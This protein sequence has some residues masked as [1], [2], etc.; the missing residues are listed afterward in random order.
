[1][2]AAVST[3]RDARVDP[4][5]ESR[6]AQLLEINAMNPIQTD[7]VIE[8]IRGDIH[9]SRHDGFLL[10]IMDHKS[11]LRRAYSMAAPG[12]TQ[13]T[14]NICYRLLAAVN[15]AKTQLGTVERGFRVHEA[16]VHAGEMM[17]HDSVRDQREIETQ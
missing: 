12:A 11:A 2:K 5:Y 8:V 16:A 7:S 17:A 14:L 10:E 6:V 15:A 4:P 3:R 9:V 13:E 1:M